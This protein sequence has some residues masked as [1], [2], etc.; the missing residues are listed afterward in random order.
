MAFKTITSLQNPLIKHIVKLRQNRDYRL[1][2]QTLVVSG[3]KQIREIAT[4]VT[5]KTLFVTDEALIPKELKQGSIYIVSEE[6]L[7]KTS[8]LKDPEGILAEVQMPKITNLNGLNKIIALDRVSDPGNLGTI[9]RTALALNWDGA[10]ILEGSCDPFNDKALSAARGAI[11]NLPIGHGS[12]DELEDI[13][14][15]NGLEPIVADLKGTPLNQME[16]P[17]KLL[18]VLSHESQGVSKRA[19]DVCQKVTIPI[20][21]KMESLNVSVAAGILMY[22]LGI[23]HAK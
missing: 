11:F 20:S 4:H 15:A 18:L 5:F 7:Q 19:E 10:F 17:E 23:N 9:L 21:H 22:E 16:K 8:G 3:I 14:H 12:W 2:H 6:V 13:I 1:E